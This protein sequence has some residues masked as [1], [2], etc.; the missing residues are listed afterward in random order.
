[1]KPEESDA[2]ITTEAPVTRATVRL[3]Q[4][5]WARVKRLATLHHRT[6]GDVVRAVMEAGLRA[7][8]EEVI[9]PKGRR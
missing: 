2:V 4:H 6:Q 7:A 3:Y 9:T 1:M 5:Q 8:E